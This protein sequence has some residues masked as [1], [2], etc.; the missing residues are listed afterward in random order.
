MQVGEA[1]E[2]TMESLWSRG[3]HVEARGHDAGHLSLLV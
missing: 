1:S 3:V 2:G